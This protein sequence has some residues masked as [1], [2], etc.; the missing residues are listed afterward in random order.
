MSGASCPTKPSMSVEYICKYQALNSRRNL[1]G[2][3]FSTTYKKKDY[4]YHLEKF[5]LD[6]LYPC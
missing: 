4:L 5:I 2:A 3:N 1:F 6:S